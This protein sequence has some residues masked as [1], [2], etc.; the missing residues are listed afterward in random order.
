MSTLFVVATPIGNLKDITLRALETLKTVDAIFCEDTRVTSKLLTHYEISK[1]LFRA[2]EAKANEAAE[3]IIALL[4]AGQS[5]ALVTDAGTPCVSDPGFRI[6]ARARASGA[7]I[8][9]IPGASS[10]TAALSIAGIDVTEFVF[11]GF[12]PHKKGRQTA[13]KEIAAGERPVVLFES[14]HRIL[15]LLAELEQ[16]AGEK[17][18]IVT[19]ELTKIHEAVYEGAPKEVAERLTKDGADRGEFVVIIR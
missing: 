5:V 13:L 3:K 8:E 11:L 18:V 9:V 6:V 19:K 10:L 15:K 14:P 17:K 4:E 16:Y 12:L 1:P 2:D 7:R